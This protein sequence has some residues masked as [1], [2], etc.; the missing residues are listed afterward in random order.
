M[1][2]LYAILLA[3]F[4]LGFACGIVFTRWLDMILDE[5]DKP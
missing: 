1:N 4:I 3:E 5:E 2:V